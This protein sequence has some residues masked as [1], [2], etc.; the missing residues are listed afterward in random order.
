MK[1]LGSTDDHF[2]I[3]QILYIILSSSFFFIHYQIEQ[4]TSRPSHYHV[5]WDDNNFAADDLQ[6]LTYQ[7]CHTYV[8]YVYFVNNI[9][10]ILPMSGFYFITIIFTHLIFYI[11][12]LLILLLLHLCQ[13]HLFCY[14]YLFNILHQA[15]IL[16]LLH[17]CQVFTLVFI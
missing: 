17:L 3:L 5:L 11:R 1:I 13:V 8:R 9:N 6:M 10:I 2:I 15:F 7:L 14:F 4:G 12:L 16:L